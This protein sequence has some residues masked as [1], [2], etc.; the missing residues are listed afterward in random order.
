VNA[1][2]LQRWTIVPGTA[3]TAG[4]WSITEKAPVDEDYDTHI[5]IG[6]NRWETKPWAP[7]GTLTVP[8]RQ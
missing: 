5:T 6:L 3:G 4:N 2:I 7:G 1:A 8:L